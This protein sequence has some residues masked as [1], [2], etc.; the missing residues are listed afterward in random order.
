LADS[1][2]TDV[3]A[4]IQSI[5][6]LIGALVPIALSILAFLK[7]H[8]N[9]K[10]IQ[11]TVNSAENIVNSLAETDKW[12]LSHQEGLTKLVEAAAT[13]PELKRAMDA[14]SIDIKKMKQDLDETTSEIKKLYDTP[15]ADSVTN[16][17]PIE[18]NLKEIDQRTKVTRT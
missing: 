7:A 17:D 11:R 9:G 1:V 13:N 18:H 12:V 15:S 8:T 3:S 5:A 14:H 2:V 16:A 10:N 6:V 4:L